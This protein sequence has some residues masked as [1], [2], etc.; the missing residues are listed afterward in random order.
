MY[1]KFLER[2]CANTCHCVLVPGKSE[3]LGFLRSRINSGALDGFYH[4]QSVALGEMLLDL[5]EPVGWKWRDDTR[6]GGGRSG[7]E[8]LAR[9]QIRPGPYEDVQLV[10]VDPGRFVVQPKVA[11]ELWRNLYRPVAFSGFAVRDTE[12]VGYRCRPNIIPSH[13]DCC[14]IGRTS[15][16]RLVGLPIPQVFIRN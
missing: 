7:G 2:K 4:P 16:V 15:F 6:A 13:N 14:G 11:F 5:F 12:C 10:G 3:F 8:P 1:F 9:T